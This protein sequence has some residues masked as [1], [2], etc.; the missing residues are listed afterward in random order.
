MFTGYSTKEMTMA[1]TPEKKVKNAV[2]KQLKLLRRF[3]IL[4]LSCN[5]WLR[6]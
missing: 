3:C 1:L 2:V 5:R 4:F 6:A